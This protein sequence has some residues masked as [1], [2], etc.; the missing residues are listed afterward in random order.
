MPHDDPCSFEVVDEIASGG[1]GT[2]YRAVG[3]RPP[4]VGRVVALKRLHPHL[5][6]DPH[7]SSMFVAE[8]QL[9]DGLR[10]PRWS[11]VIASGEDAAK[12]IAL[13]YVPG[14]ALGALM[15]IQ[16]HRPAPHPSR[17]RCTSPA[18]VAE[19]PRGARWLRG[20]DRRPED[21]CGTSARRDILVGVD[22]EVVLIDFGVAKV[23]DA[24][25]HT[26]TGVVKGKLA[27]MSPEQAQGRAIDRRT[28]VF[29]LG[30][31]LWESL[32]LQRLFRGDGE[33]D[34]LRKLVEEAP[35]PVAAL[36][37]DA[38][39]AL[40]TVLF[41][42]LA[43]DVGDRTATSAKLAAELRA[44]GERCVGGPEE[45]ARFFARV[46]PE[47]FAALQRPVA[48]PLAAEHLQ[49]VTERTVLPNRP[50]TEL[51]PFDGWSGARRR[52]G[53]SSIGVWFAAFGVLC[54]VAVL[55]FYLGARRAAVPPPVAS[56]PTLSPPRRAVSPGAVAAPP[57]AQVLV[58]PPPPPTP[59]PRVAARPQPPSR[60][61]SAQRRAAPGRRVEP[62]G[63]APATVRS[64]LSRGWDEH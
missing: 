34:T 43:K 18:R 50:M 57:V 60:A 64:L 55:A 53:A 40:D 31:V 11:K 16:T 12:W 36:R 26:R 48:E 14:V 15:L 9:L 54:L 13:Q 38:P 51:V 20:A 5:A 3:A 8:A 17:G 56:A 10:H 46:L 44:V 19:A 27:Y 42:A 28:D 1:M 61:A 33:L 41:R 32:T 21:W 47:R 52:G 37:A 49:D 58:A 62:P 24:M 4:F 59:S 39:I 7:V 23:R 2:V 22:G 45:L 6:K 25:T 29:A 30:V 35:Q 63:E